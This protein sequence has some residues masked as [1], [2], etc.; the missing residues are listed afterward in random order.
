LSRSKSANGETS[1]SDPTA[2]TL[3]AELSASCEGERGGE[4]VYG[5]ALTLYLL[6][7][8][9]GFP[10][11]YSFEMELV[12]R[13]QVD[14][15]ETALHEAR[16][17]IAQLSNSVSSLME[18]AANAYRQLE[19]KKTLICVFRSS[20]ATNS[21]G[22]VSWNKT[23][24]NT[25]EATLNAHKVVIPKSGLYQIHVRLTMQDSSGTGSI[26]LNVKEELVAESICG[27]NTG[28]NCSRNLTEFLQLKEGDS[29][30]VGIKSNHNSDAQLKFSHFSIMYLG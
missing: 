20:T 10:L 6:L 9:V 8:V 26:Y 4:E 23:E 24:I 19:Q 3:D 15:L 30:C 7:P 5:T 18:Q 27:F 21:N 25:L 14:V 13:E 1:K 28:Y 2:P 17:E 16:E 12:N 11:E 29:L 22:F